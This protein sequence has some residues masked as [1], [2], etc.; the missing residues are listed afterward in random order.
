MNDN[1][2]FSVIVP[3]YNRAG[4]ITRTIESVLKQSYQHFEIIVVDDGSTDNTEEVVKSILSDKITYYRIANAERA[5]ARN[6]GMSKAKG[7]YITFLDSDDLLYKDY[8]SNAV[9]SLTKYGYPVFF[10]LAYESWSDV[11]SKSLIKY[12]VKND[13]I[14]SLIRGNHLSCLGIFLK[15]ENVRNFRFNED[16]NLSGSEDWELWLRLAANFGLKTDPRVSAALVVHDSRSVLN[17]DEE[18]LLHRKNLALQYSF[19]NA[20]VKRVY[21][22]HRK[23]MDAYCDTYIALHLALSME[24]KKALKYFFLSVYYYPDVFFSKRTLAI[25]KY[26]VL[27]ILGIRKK[28]VPDN[29]Y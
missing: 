16:R 6:T 1:I 12:S 22:K 3:T 20:A 19:E 10:H 28:P 24:N 14:Y 7:D 17:Y 9:Q 5:A 23:E 8:L 26:I 15:R 18:K 13:D 2:F 4:F 27:N 21:G 29:T 25:F 11:K